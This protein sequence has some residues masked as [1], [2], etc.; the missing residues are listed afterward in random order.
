MKKPDKIYAKEWIEIHPYKNISESDQFYV[1]L[2]N[3]LLPITSTLDE[4][5]GTTLALYVAA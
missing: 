3:N 4:Q 5:Q 2:A 1:K